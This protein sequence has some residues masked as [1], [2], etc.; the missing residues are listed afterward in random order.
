MKDVAM[1]DLFLSV[2]WLISFGENKKMRESE[3]NIREKQ[4]KK[5]KKKCK[6]RNKQKEC[7]IIKRTNL[8]R[9][10][11]QDCATLTSVVAH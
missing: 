2:L 7:C 9:L 10:S 3:K 1:T 4:S 6:H 11:C 5:Q 8:F